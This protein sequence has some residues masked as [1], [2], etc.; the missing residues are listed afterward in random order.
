MLAFLGDYIYEVHH[1][2]FSTHMHDR[3]SSRNTHT[4]S[5][6]QYGDYIYP[7]KE[8]QHAR[9]GTPLDPP[10]EAVTL[11]DYRRRSAT[12]KE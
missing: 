9:A 12:E 5:Y 6:C 8:E 11:Q 2:T 3:N 4:I 1:A 7:S 10:G